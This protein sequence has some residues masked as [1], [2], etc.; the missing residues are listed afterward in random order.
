MMR[1]RLRTL[2]EDYQAY[3]RSPGNQVCHYLG[4][5]LIAFTLLGLLSSIPVGQIGSWTVDLAQ[6]V[7]VAVIVYD[8]R[9]SPR[10]ATAFAVV[11]V[12]FYLAARPLP[13]SFHWVGF[14]VGWGLQ[15]FG[16][17]V[18]EGKSP[19]FFKNLQHVMT[20]PLWVVSRVVPGG[21]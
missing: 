15:F 21:E 8:F 13:L 6:I 4:I 5:P 16:H 19:A 12:V 3:H 1:P 2:F 14:V 9:L 10:L 20:G 11:L 7:A 17:Y 18:Y